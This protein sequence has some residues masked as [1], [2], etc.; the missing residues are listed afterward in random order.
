MILHQNQILTGVTDIISRN[1]GGE[2]IAFYHAMRELKDAKVDKLELFDSTVKYMAGLF[3][4]RI[5]S[6]TQ[7]VHIDYSDLVL[8]RPYLPSKVDSMIGST[9]FNANDGA[10]FNAFSEDF[11]NGN[12]PNLTSLSF[13]DFLSGPKEL[14][15]VMGSKCAQN[16]EDL[17]FHNSGSLYM[18]PGKT[19]FQCLSRY[20]ESLPL[21]F[22]DSCRSFLNA[23]G[24]S[25]N[26]DGLKS[27]RVSFS[28]VFDS[29]IKKIAK[30]KHMRNLSELE[31]IYCKTV[32]DAAL[33]AFMNTNLE[34][35]KSIN[36]KGNGDGALYTG[37]SKDT[38]S[39]LRE[40]YAVVTG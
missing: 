23:V 13:L 40:E 33:R 36:I 14:G 2:E 12:L 20:E 25:R 31:F 21:P 5:R 17:S 19:Y 10:S 32:S 26:L 38:I 1:G 9:H 7:P 15:K 18:K 35:L 29:G 37:V 30:N 3:L 8:L 4:E 39:R 16:L 6:A 11:C 27:L 22:V 24:S 34:S 28:F